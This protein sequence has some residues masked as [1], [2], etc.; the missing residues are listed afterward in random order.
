MHWL[1]A[2]YE[3]GDLLRSADNCENGHADRLCRS[4]EYLAGLRA[5]AAWEPFV[6]KSRADLAPTIISIIEKFESD[7]KSDADADHWR[8]KLAA[9][10]YV[11]CSKAYRDLLE[12][13]LELVEN[14]DE[15]LRILAH[16]NSL[17]SYGA[18]PRG[19]GN[20][21][22]GSAGI[23]DIYVSNKERYKNARLA[24]VLQAIDV[25]E[26]LLYKTPG[27]TDAARLIAGID[28]PESGNAIRPKLLKLYKP[29]TGEDKWYWDI[30]LWPD[31]EKALART[32]DG[33]DHS[34]NL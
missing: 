17:A 10:V 29:A 8:Y 18:L 14:E 26:E 28:S 6:E 20:K 21:G 12:K 19:V 25:G 16:I 9:R 31:F 30:V 32:I 1:I 23:L 22:V 27:I 4:V 5:Y 15:A 3:S 2:D 13:V 33:D 7:D 24:R 34:K 11:E